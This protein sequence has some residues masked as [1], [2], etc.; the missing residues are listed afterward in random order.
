MPIINNDDELKNLEENNIWNHLD[1]FLNVYNAMLQGKWKWINNSDCK[2]V[3]LRIDMRD[4]GCII[5]NRDHKRITPNQLS[6]Q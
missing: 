6:K 1:D 5:M 4:G 3:D 2:Y